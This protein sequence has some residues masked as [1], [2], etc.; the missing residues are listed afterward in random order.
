MI[1]SNSSPLYT[2]H[3]PGKTSLETI[4]LDRFCYRFCVLSRINP[5]LSM[6]L[7]KLVT[8]TVDI[9]DSLRLGLLAPICVP[10]M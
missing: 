1:L 2:W 8:G 9:S 3:A 4:I 6:Q 7:Q 10:Y 5:L